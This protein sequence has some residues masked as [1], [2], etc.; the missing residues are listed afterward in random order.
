MELRGSV[1]NNVFLHLGFGKKLIRLHANQ[2]RSRFDADES[3]AS[4]IEQ[5]PWQILLKEHQEHSRVEVDAVIDEQRQPN[6]D[7]EQHPAIP[8]VDST[9]PVPVTFLATIEPDEVIEPDG[10]AGQ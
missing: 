9:A 4:Q 8:V 2:L 1:N 5:L 6:S 10:I 3:C 7:V